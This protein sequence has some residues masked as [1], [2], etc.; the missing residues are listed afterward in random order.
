MKQ[1][2]II[3]MLF[4]R[5]TTI[6]QDSSAKI[7]KLTFSGYIKDLQWVRFDKNFSKGYY[8]N[9][10]HNRINLK[11]KPSEI[12]TGRLEIRNRFYWGED[13]SIP[14]FK[15]QLRNENEAADLSLTV[16][17]TRKAIVHTNI[18][19]LWFE[20][21]RSKW[22]VR[23]GRQRMNWGIT[24][25][26]NPNDIFN[27]YNFLD[28]DYE[29]RPGSDAIR[30]QYL[31]TDLS[32]IEVAMA[33]TQFDPIAAIR[34]STNFKKYDLQLLAGIYQNK[35]TAGIGWAGSISD[36]GFKG[37]A[38]LYSGRRDSGMN[39]S[40][41]MEADYIFGKGWYLSAGLLYN[42]YGL[43]TPVTDW[44][45]ISFRMAPHSLMPSKWSIIVNSSKEFTPIFSGSISAV[46][47]PQVN[48]LILFPSFKYNV[49]ENMDLDLVWQS[50]FTELL[51]KFQAVSHTGYVRIK[52]SF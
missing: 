9:L 49:G 2:L 13:V 46:Y 48:M 38:Q 41:T 17:D 50:F 24:N 47:S 44:S 4:I 22:N 37:E 20:Y 5:L 26:W 52:W 15:E 12:I 10:V 14:G 11:W 45:S 8:T 29:E 23:A 16:V 1:L 51:K 42:H 21:R 7:N 6:A 28:F 27:S 19:R 34:Y 30:Y 40:A 33:V 39:L 35:F 18:E 31:I 36:V 32:N 43:N 3:L 25:I